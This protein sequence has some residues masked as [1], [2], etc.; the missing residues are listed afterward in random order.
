MEV[1]LMSRIVSATTAVALS[2]AVAAGSAQAAQ[3]YAPAPAGAAASALGTAA[4]GANA[5]TF[6]GMTSQFP[7]QK[8]TENQMC[9]TLNVFMTKDM[10]RVKRLLIGFEASCNSEDHIYGTT[11]SYTGLP[12][13]RSRH[14]TTAAFTRQGAVDLQLGGGLT[15][16]ATTS[17]RGKVSYGRRGSGTFEITV[18]ITDQTGQT[19]DTCATGVLPY[20]V[21][22]LKRA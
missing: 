16:H 15:A 11:W 2:I 19:I 22:A 14:N 8:D 12:T 13:T 20:H 7:C 21:Q 18:A 4:A 9:G 10:K 1:V 17:L 5:W 3:R 6:V